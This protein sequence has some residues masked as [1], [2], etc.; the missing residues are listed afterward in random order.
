MAKIVVVTGAGAGV[1]RATVEAFARAGY[2]VAL[3]SRD[4]ARLER[5]RRDLR[6]SAGAPCRSPPTSPMPTRWTPRPSGSSGSSGPSTCGSTSPW[7]P[8]SRRCQA[9]RRRVR[10]RHAGHL[11]R[12]GAWHDGGPAPHAPR[13]RGTIV[14][15]GS[16]LAYRSVPLQSIYCG[17]KFAIRGFTDCAAL[18]AH[19]RQAR[20]PPHHGRPAGG[21][22][23]AVRLGDEQDGPAGDAGAADL[24]AR[25]AGARHPVRRHP[26]PAARSGSA[27]RP[28]RRSSPTASRPASSTA[29]WPRRATP[30]SSPTR[31]CRRTRRPTCSSRCR[32]TTARTGGSTRRRG[33]A[34]GRCSPIAIATAF[35]A[36]AGLGA[37]TGLHLLAKKYRV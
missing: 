21:E 2:D 37:L 35:W 15:V 17:A 29:I 8:C 5:R 7:R 19:P 30:A 33:P 12:A 4:P 13:N 27:F 23:A 9:H 22:H 24:P 6:R 3:L 18:R 1:G 34:A 20:H 14:N 32:A 28:S 25:G 31:R 11:P 26:P 16:A 10:A 36:A